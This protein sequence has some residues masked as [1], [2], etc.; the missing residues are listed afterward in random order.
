ML[1][2]KKMLGAATFAL[3]GVF[4]CAGVAHADDVVM[5]DGDNG[6]PWSWATENECLTSGP[7][8]T[9]TDNVA[10]KYLKYWYCAQGDGG[11]WYLH[12][13]NNTTQP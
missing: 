13:T 11:L 10:D 5:T 6:I 9:L 12:N 4:M 3:G 1:D 7:D 2:W 8:M